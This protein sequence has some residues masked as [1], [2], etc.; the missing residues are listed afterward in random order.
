MTVNCNVRFLEVGP[1]GSFEYRLA[2][3]QI[4]PLKVFLFDTAQHDLQS[5]IHAGQYNK[6]EN[7]SMSLEIYFQSSELHLNNYNHPFPIQNG[8]VAPV[9]PFTKIFK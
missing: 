7:I 1:C 5:P 6:R 3:L 2:S 9:Q 4:L 8:S